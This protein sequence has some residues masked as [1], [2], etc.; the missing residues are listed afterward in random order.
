MFEPND[1]GVVAHGEVSE[2]DVAEAQNCLDEVASFAQLTCPDRG[3]AREL[4]R[5]MGI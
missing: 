1:N 4:E 2:V 3:G 5:S